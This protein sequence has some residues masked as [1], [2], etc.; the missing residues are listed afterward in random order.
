MQHKLKLT[1]LAFALSL[2]SIAPAQAGGIP[3]IDAANLAQTTASAVEEVAQTLKQIEEYA[4]QLKQYE[5]QLMQAAAPDYI[6]NDAQNAIN[7]LLNAYDALAGYEKQFGDLDAYI[8][9]FQNLDYIK[10]HPCF[11]SAGCSDEERAELNRIEKIANDAQMN[12]ALAAMQAL[13]E[14]RESLQKDADHL[15]NLQ[16]RASGAQGRMEALGYANQFASHQSTQLLQIR[17]LL[18]T[19][20]NMVAAQMAKQ[21]EKEERADRAFEKAAAAG[22]EWAKTPTNLSDD[23]GGRRVTTDYVPTIKRLH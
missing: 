5:D 23:E 2:A 16:E 21:A 22:R 7:G 20:Q 6:W 14:N 8:S 18:L 13:Q 11:T 4:L 3:V 15:R 19:Q 17:G 12:S 10:D 1:A 9:K